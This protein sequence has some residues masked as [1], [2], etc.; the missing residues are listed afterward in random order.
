MHGYCTSLLCAV[1][2]ATLEM[3]THL[4][5]RQMFLDYEYRTTQPLMIPL[6]PMRNR[7]QTAVIKLSRPVLGVPGIL[8]QPA[9]TELFIQDHTG[10]FDALIQQANY[11]CMHK[12]S[13]IVSNCFRSQCRVL[14]FGQ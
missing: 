11:C 5:Q 7:L 13:N 1:A 4:R 6:S 3:V 8:P 12:Q 10:R 14:H 2:T 9:S